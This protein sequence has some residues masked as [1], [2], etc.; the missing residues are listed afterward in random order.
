MTVFSADLSYLN[1]F[2]CV[3][4]QQAERW[5]NFKTMMPLQLLLF[6]FSQFEIFKLIEKR[7]FKIL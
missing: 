5:Q 3:Y 6:Y 2:K 7:S 4:F 1:Y